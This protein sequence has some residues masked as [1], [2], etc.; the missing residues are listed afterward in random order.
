MQ[1]YHRRGVKLIEL[2]VVMAILILL[3]GIVYVLTGSSREASRRTQCMNNLRQIAI[4]NY[5]YMI[6]LLG[7]L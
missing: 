5:Q 3:A 7:A 1:G 4:A 6:G 2:L